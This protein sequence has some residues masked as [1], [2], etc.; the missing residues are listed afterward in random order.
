MDVLQFDRNHRRC[1]DTRVNIIRGGHDRSLEQRCQGAHRAMALTNN[2]YVADQV[3]KVVIFWKEGYLPPIW[4]RSILKDLIDDGFIGFA[5]ASGHSSTAESDL[6]ED[7]GAS[8]TLAATATA[9]ISTIVVVVVAA[10]DS[11]DSARNEF[12]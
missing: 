4:Q 2:Q 12:I 1:T 6:D 8:L 5:L 11:I 10:T 9:T 3:Q 7:R